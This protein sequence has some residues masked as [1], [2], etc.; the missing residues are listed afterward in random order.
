[1][2]DTVSGNL[3]DSPAQVWV[4]PVNC[5]G[6][7]G[8]GIA[9][10][11]KERFPAMFADY[12]FYCNSGLMQP[13]EVHSWMNVSS[14]DAHPAYIFNLATKFRWCNKSRWEWIQTG[15]YQT[16]ALMKAW[17]L[18]TVAMPAL[19]C[20]EGRLD[21]GTIQKAIYDTMGYPCTYLNIKV[22]L[23]RPLDYVDPFALQS[24]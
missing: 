7:M 16:M 18:H 10:Q 14:A 23:Y 8:K 22:W 4:N 21:F 1:M 20:G 19:G 6:V 15:L 3:F 9:K 17:D 2:I 11:F 12:Q 5:E 13:G 24:S